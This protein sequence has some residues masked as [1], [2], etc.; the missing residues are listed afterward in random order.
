[1]TP[2]IRPP[3][4]W[5]CR[6]PHRPRHAHRQTAGRRSGAAPRR[7]SHPILQRRPGRLRRRAARTRIRSGRSVPAPRSGLV[8]LGL[9]ERDG[10]LFRRHTTYHTIGAALPARL[11]ATSSWCGCST[12]PPGCRRWPTWASSAPSTPSSCSCT[13]TR[14]SPASGARSAGPT[15]AA[16]P[17]LQ[18]PLRA[19]RHHLPEALRHPGRPSSPPRRGGL[20]TASPLPPILAAKW[21]AI[22]GR[23][24]P[25]SRGR[26]CRCLLPD[27][28]SVVA[29][30]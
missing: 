9:V 17:A 4:A 21:G 5:A 22:T 23:R 27:K 2:C 25:R 26:H 13:P 24:W 15:R 11:R 28:T 8:E 16:S 19:Q 12:P 7:A 1:M 10:D 14:R 6:V 30:T 20:L 3:A 18:S 29:V